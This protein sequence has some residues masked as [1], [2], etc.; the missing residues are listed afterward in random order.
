L[1]WAPEIGFEAL[2]AQMVNADRAILREKDV[3]CMMAG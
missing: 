3:S 1:D 2:V